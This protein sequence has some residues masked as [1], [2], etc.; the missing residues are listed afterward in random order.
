[1]R[2]EQLPKGILNYLW[3]FEFNPRWADKDKFA[4]LSEELE[5]F[6]YKINDKDFI[7]G[8]YNDLRGYLNFHGELPTP[9]QSFGM[10]LRNSSKIATN[11]LSYIL[12]K[13]LYSGSS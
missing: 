13:R 11:L 7:D 9:K 5:K 2:I 1:M 8:E 12:S 6:G 4:V 3:F 10:W